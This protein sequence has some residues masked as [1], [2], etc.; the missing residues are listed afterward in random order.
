MAKRTTVYL[1]DDLS[2]D[3]GDDITTVEF[4]LDGADYQIDLTA[5]NAQA[6]RSVFEP[7][8]TH[9]RRVGGRAKRSLRRTNQTAPAM[10]RQQ[11]KEVRHWA[12]RNGF[13]LSDRGRIPA[14]VLD[15]FHADHTGGPRSPEVPTFSS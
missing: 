15:A 14:E 10:T 5:P 6:L 13:T 4:G 9:A 1:V 12:K 3:T 11:A 2:G 7:Y 8:V